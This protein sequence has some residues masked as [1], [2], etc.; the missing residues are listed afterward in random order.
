M[1]IVLHL[2]RAL[3]AFAMIYDVD[4]SEIRG[5]GEEDPAKEHRQPAYTIETLK[6]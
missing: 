2:V 1:G 4:Y 3:S 6:T 5:H